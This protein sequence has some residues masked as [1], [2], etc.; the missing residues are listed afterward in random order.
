MV[1][2]GRSMAKF[3]QLSD[4]REAFDFYV[5]DSSS[6][7]NDPVA[8]T[9]RSGTSRPRAAPDAD[10]AFVEQPPNPDLN[11]DPP[12]TFEDVCASDPLVQIRKI[13]VAIRASGQRRDE[14]KE[15]IKLGMYHAVRTSKY[16]NFLRKP[17]RVVQKRLWIGHHYT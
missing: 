17:R 9:G 7:G 13:I 11:R 10:D 3:I 6:V 2:K 8:T 4:D 14:F 12:K 1:E 16:L 15:W 5:S